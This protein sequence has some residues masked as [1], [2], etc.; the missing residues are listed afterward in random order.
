MVVS[1]SVTWCVNHPRKTKLLWELVFDSS[2]SNLSDN[3][4]IGFDKGFQFVF[5]YGVRVKT[6]VTQL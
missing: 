3:A 4:M 2:I 5:S 6:N 1:P